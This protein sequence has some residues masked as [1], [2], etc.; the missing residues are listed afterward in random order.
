MRRF[1][2]LSGEPVDRQGRAL[3]RHPSRARARR[4]RCHASASRATRYSVGASAR[5]R[6]SSRGSRRQT[7]IAPSP[8]VSGNSRQIVGFTPRKSQPCSIDARWIAQPRLSCA[9]NRQPSFV[10]GGAD[11]RARRRIGIVLGLALVEPRQVADLGGEHRADRLGAREDRVALGEID[12]AAVLAARVELLGVRR[13]HRAAMGHAVGDDA[14]GEHR[15]L[16]AR[17]TCG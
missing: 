11:D 16:G 4:R 5:T 15:D 6:T 14:A 7:T 3:R 12:V 1:R 17:E 8:Y 2:R 10:H 13:L 9:R